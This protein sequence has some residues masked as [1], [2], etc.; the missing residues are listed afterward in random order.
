M[1]TNVVMFVTT[2]AI[3]T[4]ENISNYT[5]NARLASGDED[6]QFVRYNREHPMNMDWYPTYYKRIEQGLVQGYDKMPKPED[7]TWLRVFLNMRDNW[8][9]K[10]VILAIA[11]WLQYHVP[12]S[13]VW[14][15]PDS[16]PDSMFMFTVDH[17]L[18]DAYV[19]AR[20][21]WDAGTE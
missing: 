6:L 15:G 2:N 13:T 16:S 21:V 11:A 1:G 9:N 18:W 17:L 8:D 14:Y 20:E 19:R 7:C 5:Q 10:P 4:D 3:L 12:V